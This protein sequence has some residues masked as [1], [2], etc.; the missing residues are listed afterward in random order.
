MGEETTRMP[1]SYGILVKP[2]Y[3]L[4][5]Y[6]IGQTVLPWNYFIVIPAFIVYSIAFVFSLK[7]LLKEKEPFRFF[8]LLL[9]IPIFIGSFITDL[10]PRYFL[11]IV[12][13]YTL[14]IARG[15]TCF[16]NKYLQITLL[17]VMTI[18]SVYSLHNY[19][20]QNEFHI[21]AHIDPWREVGSYLRENVKGDDIIFNIGGVPIN[22]YTGFDIPVLGENA[23]RTIKS[24]L[25]RE[26]SFK[27]IWL[28]VSNTKYEEEGLDATSYLK[29][30]YRLQHEK[31]Y[32]EDKSYQLKQ[33]LFKKE[34]FQ[35]RIKIYQFSKHDQ[36]G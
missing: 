5:T 25:E 10:M 11:F 4:Y 24:E 16:A 36:Y 26:N 21:L 15:I 19:Y 29:Q 6:S 23:Q 32:L 20:K 13:A 22:H 30:H 17:S 14:I 3:L 27:R 7:C 9:S 2:F 1:I 31:K 8:F 18:L 33:K 35:H 28:V 12:P 34:F